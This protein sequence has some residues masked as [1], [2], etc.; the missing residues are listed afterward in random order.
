VFGKTVEEISGAISSEQEVSLDLRLNG[1][2]YTPQ[3]IEDVTKANQDAY[4]EIGLKKFAKEAGI[5][6][7]PGEKDVT[8]IVEKIKTGITTTLEEK[9][10][11]QTPPE[12]LSK[13]LKSIT[14]WENKYNQL[15]ETHEG[16]KG[17]LDTS[18]ASF[19]DLEG[20]IK[21]KERNSL[22]RSAF[23]EK[24]KFDKE[25]GLLIFTNTHEFEETESGATQIKKGGNILLNKL[26]EPETL[27]NVVKGFTEDKGWMGKKGN[28]GEDRNRNGDP[29]GMTEEK[30]I[31]YLDEKGVDSMSEEGGKL[32]L[33]IT[34]EAKE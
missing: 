8:V 22:I 16:V 21:I 7:L 33:E 19:T 9:Y 4:I 28:S 23:P 17:D 11:N 12:E 34:S 24:M 3:Q 26:G 18:K 2:V 27:E 1:R 20:K 30:A 15:F 13:A 31:E 32:F 10:K 6:L 5:E 29:R 14:E 25:D